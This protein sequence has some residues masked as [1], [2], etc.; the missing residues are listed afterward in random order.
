MTEK[1]IYALYSIVKHVYE[2][3]DAH[4]HRDERW[5]AEND[6]RHSIYIYTWI[7][8]KCFM[9]IPFVFDIY[10]FIFT[11]NGKPIKCRNTWQ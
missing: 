7:Y 3:N 10:K 9:N 11:I 4:N 8:N 6:A 2:N 5:V 1:Y